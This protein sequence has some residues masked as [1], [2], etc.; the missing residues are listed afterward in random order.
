MILDEMRALPEQEINLLDP[1]RVER[2]VEATGWKRE[3]RNR[4]PAHGQ[5][6]IE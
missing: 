1:G 4:S 6:V 2:Y 3:G 5:P